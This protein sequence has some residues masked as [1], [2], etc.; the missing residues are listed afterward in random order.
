LVKSVSLVHSVCNKS[1]HVEQL[2]TTC[3]FSG[4]LSYSAVLCLMSGLSNKTDDA[5]NDYKVK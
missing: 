4:L 3:M 1:L 5:N 2:C